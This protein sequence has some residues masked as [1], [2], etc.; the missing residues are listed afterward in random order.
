MD[1]HKANILFRYLPR[2]Y[3]SA[4]FSAAQ[5]HDA[6]RKF[7][8][9]IKVLPDENNRNSFFLLFIQK[10]INTVGRIDIQSAD[11]IRYNQDRRA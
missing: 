7:D 11:R 3:N 2:I 8:Q 9:H 1:H 4:H 5:Y 6:V 10:L